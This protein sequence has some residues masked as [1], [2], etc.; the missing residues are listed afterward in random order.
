MLDSQRVSGILFRSTPEIA[1]SE[2]FAVADRAF[3]D[4]EVRAIWLAA[5]QL[6]SVC[7]INRYDPSAWFEGAGWP[8]W[9]QRLIAG[10]VPVSL[11]AFGGSVVKAR[12]YPYQSYDHQALPGPGAA[13]IFGAAVTDALPEERALIVDGKILAGELPASAVSTPRV[14]AESGIRFAEVIADSA[15]RV[16]SVDTNPRITDISVASTVSTYLARMFHDYLYCR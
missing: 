11:F 13:K 2:D 1:F 12:W 6:D 10:G 9:R 7:A 15:G 5:M 16:L 3:C 8:V 4:A 14:L